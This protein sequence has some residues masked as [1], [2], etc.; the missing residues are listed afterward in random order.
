MDHGF[1]YSVKFVLLLYMDDHYLV[2]KNNFI[3]YL[4]SFF[5]NLNKKQ[6][7]EKYDHLQEQ[8]ISF[9]FQDKH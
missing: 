3:F 6:T 5:F 9:L 1:F 2:L 4:I 8:L 7:F